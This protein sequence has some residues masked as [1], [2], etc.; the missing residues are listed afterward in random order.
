MPVAGSHSSIIRLRSMRSP[1]LSTQPTPGLRGSAPRNMARLLARQMESRIH[2][3]C[4]WIRNWPDRSI[5]PCGRGNDSCTCDHQS[6]ND[7]PDNSKFDCETREDDN[8]TLRHD[9]MKSNA[10][11][12]IVLSYFKGNQARLKAPSICRGLDP[13]HSVDRQCLA[14]SISVAGRLLFVYVNDRDLAIMLELQ[15]IVT[16]SLAMDFT[17]SEVREMPHCQPASMARWKSS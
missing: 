6:I 1:V 12:F 7:F 16:A 14:R 13:I 5:K 2:R 15:K 4:D 8:L 17:S 11:S 9:T 10:L 3:W